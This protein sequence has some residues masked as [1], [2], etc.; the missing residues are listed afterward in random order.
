MKFEFGPEPGLKFG[1]GFGPDTPQS[2]GLGLGWALVEI[3][4]ELEFFVWG[5]RVDFGCIQ[6]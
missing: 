1:F 5:M 2:M 4:F 3:G 6:Y